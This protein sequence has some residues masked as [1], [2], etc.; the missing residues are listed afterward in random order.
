MTSNNQAYQALKQW[1][2]AL[3]L[4]DNDTESMNASVS[5]LQA[6]ATH[7]AQD[8]QLYERMLEEAMHRQFP[9]SERDTQVL[10]HLQQVLHLTDQEVR[11]VRD[12]LLLQHAHRLQS[13]PQS[14]STI[15]SSAAS[16]NPEADSAYP[17]YPAANPAL[18]PTIAP[19]SAIAGAA[20]PQTRISRPPTDGVSAA[21]GNHLQSTNKELVAKRK[22]EMEGLSPEPSNLQAQ[23]DAQPAQPMPAP[24]VVAPPVVAP[25][26]VSQPTVQAA[27]TEIQPPAPPAAATA[28]QT[29]YSRASSRITSPKIPWYKRPET[30]LGGLFAIALGIIGGAL[31]ANRSMNQISTANPEAAKPLV[32]AGNAK[33][34]QSNYKGAI[35]DYSNALSIDNRNPTTYFNR[36][37]AYHR[38]GDLDKAESDLDKAIDLNPNLA[39][40]LNNRSHVRFDKRQ[41]DQALNDA[42]RAI[43]LNPSLA[44]A[45]LNR[46]NVVFIKKDLKGATEAFNKAISLKPNALTLARAYNNLGNIYAAEPNIDFAIKN[47]DQATQLDSKYADA[48][49]NRALALE[50][51]KDIQAALRGYKD[52]AGQYKNQGNEDMSRQA[53]SQADRLQQI[54]PSPSPGQSTL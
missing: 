22:L 3:K 7:N 24:P 27:Q 1:Q 30:I 15:S 5:A 33:S 49:Y 19:A 11:N 42:D 45:Y 18:N 53:Q 14:V 4:T 44:E 37:T 16:F 39:E 41:Y 25:P 43:A 35:D 12:R 6:P 52:A 28:V 38:I 20:L 32:E 10:A 29:P 34:Q 48:F 31:L 17:E 54:N 2:K 21:P 47:Y 40:A 13:T 51:K 36:G 26:V 9:L 50:A 8:L 46:G 23:P